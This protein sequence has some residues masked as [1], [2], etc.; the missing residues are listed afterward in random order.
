MSEAKR[1]YR[2]PPC[3]RFD[4]AGTESWLED[5]AARGFILDKDSFLFDIATFEL[6]EPQSI[7][8]RLEPTGTNG[9]ILSPDF[10]PKA[11]AV[12]LNQ[13]MGWEYRGRRGQFHIYACSDPT[14][15]ELHTD[16]R[17]QAIAMKGLTKYLWSNLFYV[18]ADL[19]L[20]YFAFYEYC[21]MTFGVYIGFGLTGLLL[22]FILSFPVSHIRALVQMSRLRRRLRDGIP[23][24]HRA[25]HSKHRTPRYILRFLR[26]AIGIFLFFAVFS[27]LG[28]GLTGENVIPLAEY[29]GTCPF[30]TL[31]ELFPESRIDPDGAIIDSEVTVW[32]NALAPVNYEYTEYADVIA[33]DGTRS[34][35]YLYLNYHEFRFEWMAMALAK[36]FTGQTQGSTLDRFFEEPPE[37]TYLTLPGVDYAVSW[38]DYYPNLILCRDGVVLRVRYHSEMTPYYTPEELA[39]ALLGSGS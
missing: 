26:P 17:I 33:P 27:R 15:P 31:E 20:Y 3:P 18:I 11:D 6:G 9:G 37:L 24:E 29:D 22:A 2:I 14:A 4:I 12:T 36:E 25:D 30:S 7:R 34:T 28:Q 16:P 21:L 13:E 10:D 35:G 1:I 5:M 19:I 32:S 8:Y 39:Q 23:L 38:T